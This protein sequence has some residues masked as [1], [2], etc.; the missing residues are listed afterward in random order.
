MWPDLG[1]GYAG[2][3]RK[4]QETAQA[5]AKVLSGTLIERRRASHFVN[6]LTARNSQSILDADSCQLLVPLSR[7]EV[8]MSDA[9]NR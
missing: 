6:E 1:F 7:G 9:A 2:S 4:Q 8:R 3:G 5:L